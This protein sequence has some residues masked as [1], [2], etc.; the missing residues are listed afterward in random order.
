MFSK[1]VPEGWE[2]VVPS[3]DEPSAEIPARSGSRIVGR[4]LPLGYG[5]ERYHELHIG[6]EQFIWLGDDALVYAKN[7]QEDFYHYNKGV[8]SV[9]IHLRFPDFVDIHKGIYAIKKFNL[10]TGATETLVDSSPGGASR[11]ELS[12]DKATLAFVRRVR[13]KEMLVLRCFG[14]LEP[15]LFQLTRRL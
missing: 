4:T 6:P 5:S 10:T 9:R 11:P 2:Y 13:D 14:Y 12:H 1:G 15:V 3:S 8:L 7:V